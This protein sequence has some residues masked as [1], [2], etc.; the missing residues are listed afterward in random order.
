[1]RN[2][3]RE[4]DTLVYRFTWPIWWREMHRP[5]IEGTH[6]RLERLARIQVHFIIIASSYV[7]PTKLE[8]KMLI[9]KSLCWENGN[10]QTSEL[11]YSLGRELPLPP[12]RRSWDSTLRHKL[13]SNQNCPFC[14][15]LG[16]VIRTTK[17]LFNN[18]SFTASCVCK[19]ALDSEVDV[20]LTARTSTYT[21]A[22]LT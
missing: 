15:D 4:K 14:Q 13:F 19:V 22:S 2:Y 3:V 21:D 20:N 1:M 16:G 10:I 9:A 17:L 11:R 7:F 5:P 8:K 12:P 18:G 6:R